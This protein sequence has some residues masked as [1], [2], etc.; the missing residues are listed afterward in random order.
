MLT[1]H[2]STLGRTTDFGG[3]DSERRP[4]KPTAGDLSQPGP[5]REAL[6]QEID[7]LRDAAEQMSQCAV[8]TRKRDTT[9]RQGLCRDYSQSILV[10]MEFLVDYHGRDL[11][12]EFHLWVLDEGARLSYDSLCEG[13]IP[14]AVQE[15][16]K[17]GTFLGG[18]IFAI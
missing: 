1:R 8:S 15:T 12:K 6:C 18:T 9:F 2:A 16:K 14:A 10:T 13:L 17:T 11:L 5:W 4:R 3:A 7:R